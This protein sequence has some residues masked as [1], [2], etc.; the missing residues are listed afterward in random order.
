MSHEEET[1]HTV[2]TW[3]GVLGLAVAVALP[4]LHY[5]LEGGV[6]DIRWG[7]LTGVV[8]ILFVGSKRVKETVTEWIEAWRGNK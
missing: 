6:P 3:I 7:I 8:G 4:V 2:A 1:A 5:F